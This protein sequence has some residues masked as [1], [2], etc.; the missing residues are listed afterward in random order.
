MSFH[1]V[2]FPATISL[3][4]SGGPE[5]K[6]DIVTL[7]NGYEERNAVWAHS[8]RRYDAGIGMSS[9]D[10]LF[11]VTAFFEAR[12]G[13]L[14]GFRWK[15]FADYKSCIP[16]GTIAPT[17]QDLGTGDGQ[18][19]DFALRKA[20]ASGEET[21]WRPINKPVANRVFVA[22][23]GQLQSEGSDYYVN[24]ETGLISFALPPA[25]GQAVTAGFEFDVPVRFELDT[26]ETNVTSFSAG[27]IPNVPVV[28]VRV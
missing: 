17:D 3:G 22:I 24:I 18:V 10:D 2:R 9:L 25:P 12:M 8:K 26:I 15:D 13:R 6:T 23:D 11:A 16:S 7:N 4:S 20:Y 5:R 19:T 14:F 1:E 27:Q 28:E 21:Y